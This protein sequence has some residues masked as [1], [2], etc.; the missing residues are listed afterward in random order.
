MTSLLWNPL[1]DHKTGIKGNHALFRQGALAL[2]APEEALR[3]TLT[4]DNFVFATFLCVNKLAM[5]ELTMRILRSALTLDNFRNASMCRASLGM[6]PLVT[7]ETS[8]A[9]SLLIS[10]LF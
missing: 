1:P 5:L 4:A 9:L 10:N 8:H 7:S 2:A 6:F 3:F